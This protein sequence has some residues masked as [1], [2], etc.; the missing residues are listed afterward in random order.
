MFTY[1]P[2]DTCNIHV[3][4]GLGFTQNLSV[5]PSEYQY[6]TN[7]KARKSSSGKR[8]RFGSDFI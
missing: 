7:L 8:K 4:S 3:Y 2:R 5:L 6:F 1:L